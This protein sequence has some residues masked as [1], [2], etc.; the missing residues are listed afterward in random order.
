M[1]DELKVSQIFK[2]WYGNRWV[3]QIGAHTAGNVLS[4]PSDMRLEWTA[5]RPW[6]Y[7]HRVPLY[8]TYTHNGRGIGFDFSYASTRSDIW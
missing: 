6:A 3:M 2:N 5:A 4:Y 8:G 7:T 1:I